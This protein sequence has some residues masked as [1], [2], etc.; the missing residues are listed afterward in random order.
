MIV[1]VTIILI[2]IIHGYHLFVV[3]YG[4]MIGHNCCG[5]SLWLSNVDHGV[6]SAVAAGHLVD[7]WGACHG[8]SQEVELRCGKTPIPP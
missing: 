6:L 7:Q 4:S 3:N 2:T 1:L 8:N 5:L